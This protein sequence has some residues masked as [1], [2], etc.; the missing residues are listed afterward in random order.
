MILPIPGRY[1]VK[2]INLGKYS[3]VKNFLP[4][5]H[6]NCYLRTWKVFLL[7]PTVQN[8]ILQNKQC[9][10]F[11]VY[12]QPMPLQHAL[13]QHAPMKHAPAVIVISSQLAIYAQMS[14]CNNE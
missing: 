1:I 3:D 2:M 13:M 4:Q 8:H 12:P 5:M 9:P 14:H 6:A 7:Q 11:P 10:T